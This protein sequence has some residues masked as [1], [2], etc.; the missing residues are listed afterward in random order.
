MSEERHAVRVLV[1]DDDAVDRMAVRRALESGGHGAVTQEADSVNDARRHLAS[2]PYDLVVLDYD[3]PGGTG[4]EVLRWMRRSELKSPVL[5][6]TGQADEEL[7][8][9]VMKAGATDYMPKRKLSSENLAARLADILESHAVQEELRQ[10]RER[11]ALAVRSGGIGIWDLDLVEDRVSLSEEAR[12]ILRLPGEGTVSR[13]TFLARF[14]GAGAEDM[15]R[16]LDEPAGPDEHMLALEVRLQGGGWVAVQAQ[17]ILHGIGA[18]REPTRVVG[19][20][21]DVTARQRGEAGQRLL[22]EVGGVLSA[23]TRPG[24]ILDEVVNLLVDDWASLVVALWQ[25]EEGGRFRA[26]AYPSGAGPLVRRLAE[27][28]PP[29]PSD[30][31]VEAVLRSGEPHL[32]VEIDPDELARHARDEVHATLLQEIGV[33]SLAAA[34][35]QVG[36][37]TS[38]A[39]A[40]FNLR[41]DRTFDERDRDVVAELG[42]RLSGALERIRLVEET[43]AAREQAE[44]AL[45]AR[46]DMLAVVSHDLRNPIGTVMAAAALLEL[47][48]LPQEK[49]N[50]QLR[51]IQRVTAQMNDLVEGLLDVSRMEAG[52]FQVE[53]G[54]LDVARLLTEA[55]ETMGPQ[56]EAR[57]QRVL[58]E[59]A[60]E[61]PVIRGDAARMQ[62]VLANLVG[63]AVK[64]AGKGATIRLRG[65]C[66]GGEM[67]IVVADDGPG[68]PP[69]E[70]E[71]I[72]ERFWRGRGDGAGAGLGLAIAR[73]IVQAH[74]GR[75]WAAESDQGGLAVHVVLPAREPPAGD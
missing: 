29:G 63:N 15:A 21:R 14:E 33:R 42:R 1:V 4:L 18:F 55:R 61:L 48:D 40:L 58:V 51:I 28:Y 26:A 49:R 24:A 16:W 38:G 30:P 59:L 72:F 13:E 10:A 73:G 6:L 37:R 3:L 70:A 64:H 31:G 11:L 44:A 8:A 57:D 69:D 27:H 5:I 67:Q 9:E 20:V 32:V 2:K 34:P 45:G 62:Q 54:S 23:A 19:T 71:S 12:S 52:E 65:R 7:V 68:L 50:R 17:S 74:G 46:E 66:E 22:A 41:G 36:G 47:E 25:P 56:A 53:A 43:Q 60:D 39:L 35:L 75:I